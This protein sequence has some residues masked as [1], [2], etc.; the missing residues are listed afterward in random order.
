[1]AGHWFSI[2]CLSMTILKT[3]SLNTSNIKNQNKMSILKSAIKK[4]SQKINIS[5]SLLSIYSNKSGYLN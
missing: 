2:N 5:A 3:G 4:A 1:M